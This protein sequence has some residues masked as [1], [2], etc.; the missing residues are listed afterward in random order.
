MRER[1]QVL[2]EVVDWALLRGLW[3]VGEW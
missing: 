3:L 2:K 1:D